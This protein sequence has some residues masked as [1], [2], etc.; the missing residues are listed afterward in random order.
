MG[1]ETMS[2]DV[3]R[4]H[5]KIFGRVQGVSFRYYT[6]REAS[7]WGLTGWVANRFDGSVELIAEG[8][9]AALHK[10][11]NY[12]HRGSPSARVE[13]V[14]VEWGESTGEFSR[15]RVQYRS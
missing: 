15:F 2:K 9:K 13:R 7:V 5:A 8:E 6:A 4:L 11:L 14:Q 10:L 12:L 1:R 3:A